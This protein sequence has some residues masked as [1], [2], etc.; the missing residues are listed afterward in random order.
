MVGSCDIMKNLALLAVVFGY[1]CVC[2]CTLVPSR[3]DSVKI[4]VSESERVGAAV[5]SVLEES[6]LNG[7]GVVSGLGEFIALFVAVER[8]YLA[9]REAR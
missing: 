4:P 6:D 1:L 3:L 7:D 2:G 9:S 5:V 8:V